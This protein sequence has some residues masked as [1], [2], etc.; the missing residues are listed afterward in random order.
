MILAWGFFLNIGSVIGRYYKKPPHD[1]FAPR[2]FEWHATFQ[3]VGF[4]LALASGLLIIVHL[5]WGG[6]PGNHLGGL[7]Q[8]MGVALL[9]CAIAQPI[10][11]VEAHRDFLRLRGPGR[12]H[13]PHRW[14]G[15]FLMIAS[16]PT[17]GFGF[18]ELGK[19]IVQ[20]D[21]VVWLAFAV[22][23][24]LGTVIVSYGEWSLS[25]VA[26]PRPRPELE[27]N[28]VSQSV[29]GGV[30]DEEHY[31]TDEVDEIEEE[32]LSSGSVN[33]S[34][35]FPQGLEQEDGRTVVDFVFAR[36]EVLRRERKRSQTI[37]LCYSVLTLGTVLFIV[38]YLTNSYRNMPMDDD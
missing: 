21:T 27:L 33:G 14:L 12:F 16:V 32:R 17:L 19:H 24:I 29:D 38:G 25:G 35:Q 10:I 37:L 1:L 3:T 4:F 5:S 6:L 28:E 34:P 8:I 7:H 26:K 30:V 2:W 11:G 36:E 13:A 15:R 23:V 18:K 22:L 9:L 20:I 31:G